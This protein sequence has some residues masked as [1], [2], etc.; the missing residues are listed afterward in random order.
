MPWR[1]ID[2]KAEDIPG[3]DG[4]EMVTDSTKVPVPYKGIFFFNNVPGLLDEVAEVVL[5][6]DLLYRLQL[7]QLA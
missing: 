2:Y 3:R 5:G 1:D 6:E 7:Q 4:C